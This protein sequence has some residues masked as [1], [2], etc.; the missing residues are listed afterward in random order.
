MSCLVRASLCTRGFG[1][2]QIVDGDDVIYGRGLWVKGRETKVKHTG[3][4][5][6]LRDP[7]PTQTPDAKAGA[8]LPDCHASTRYHAS[9]P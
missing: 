9:L 8:S 4:Q 1:T 6:C 5:P 2:D 7:F 3:S